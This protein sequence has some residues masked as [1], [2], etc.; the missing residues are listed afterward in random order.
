VLS[1]LWTTPGNALAFERR[2]IVN[3]KYD[4]VVGWQI[5]PPVVGQENAATI[6]VSRSGTNPAQAVQGAE[7]TL[8]V[9]VSQGGQSR[10]YA[11]T[12]VV[13]QPGYYTAAFVPTRVG[14]YRWTFIGTLE[15]QNVNEAFDTTSNNIERVASAADLAFPPGL[16]QGTAESDALSAAQTAAEQARALAIAGLAV[17]ALGVVLAWSARGGGRSRGGLGRRGRFS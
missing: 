8:Q 10:P 9:Q 5:A 4:V 1:V 15:G 11:L 12:T 14:D 13:G 2:T 16:P 17:G 7:Q 3:G 6:R